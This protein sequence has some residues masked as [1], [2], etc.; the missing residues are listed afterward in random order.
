MSAVGP[1]GT[2]DDVRFLAAVGWIVLQNSQNAEQA[3]FR[4]TTKQARAADQC[5]FKRATES[6][7]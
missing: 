1:F 5:G 7:R 2:L 6:R 3:N 4:R